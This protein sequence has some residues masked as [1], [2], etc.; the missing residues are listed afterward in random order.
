MEN[1][2]GLIEAYRESV[3]HSIRTFNLL[4]KGIE[5]RGN[6]NFSKEL[7]K[8]FYSGML[9]VARHFAGRLY[10]KEP[11]MFAQW[12]LLLNDLESHFRTGFEWMSEN[13]ARFELNQFIIDLDSDLWRRF[14]KELNVSGSDLSN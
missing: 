2:R 9:S 12:L 7:A 4:I 5:E 6:Y 14:R 3:L 11:S 13:T 8:E 10:C 1:I